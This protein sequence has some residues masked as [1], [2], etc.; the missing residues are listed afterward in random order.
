MEKNR[1]IT[2]ISA[3]IM[4]ATLCAQQRGNGKLSAWVQEALTQQSTDRRAAEEHP[5]LI[6]VFIR[7]TEGK[8]LEMLQEY[9]CTIYAQLGDICIATVPMDRLAELSQQP[10]VVRIEASPSAHTTMDEVAKA[11]NVLPAYQKTAEHEAFTGKGVVMGVMD[12]GFDLSHPTFYDDTSM[13]T[14]RIKAFWDQLADCPDASR[15]PVGREYTTSE[16]I[17]TV[18]RATDGK[19]QN[20]GTHTTGI[21]AGSGYDTTYRGIAY[22][23]DI[24]LVA[25]A[26]TEDTIYINKQDLNKYTS[27]T[28]ALGFKYLFDYAEQQGRPCVVSFSEGYTAYLDEDDELYDE[29]LK[30]LTGPGRI[31]VASAGNESLNP[32]YMVKPV[33]TE[34]AGAFL[35]IYKKTGI[36]RLLTDGKPT[37]RLTHYPAVEQEGQTL[38]LCMDGE[39]WEEGELRDTLFVNKD[40]LALHITAYTSGLI[41]GKT[42]YLIRMTGN[43]EVSAIG[44]IAIVTEGSDCQ[45]ELFGSSSNLLMTREDDPR[46]NA[47]QRGHN[48]LAPGCLAAPICVGATIHRF[49]YVNS[50]GETTNCPYEV[51]QGQWGPFSSMG[52]TMGGRAK[53]DV[54]APGMYVISSMSSY[55]MEEHPDETAT[56]TAYSNANGRRY[57]WAIK[58][59]TSM[60]TPIVAGAIALWL[61]AKPTLTREDIMGILQRTCRYPEEGLTYPNE[62]YGYGEIDIYRGLLDVLGV[63]GIQ[64]ISLHQPQGVRIFACDGL[65][66]LV[67]DST[68]EQSVNLNIYSTGGSLLYKERLKAGQREIK[69]PLPIKGKGIYVVQLQGDNRVT[70]SQLIRL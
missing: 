28:D 45:A 27:A 5:M 7:T 68:P 67:F 23:S 16:E 26:V 35:G 32:T 39:R 1:I 57:S 43:I 56:H 41:E 48:V 44:H 59:G 14:Y 36:Y 31:L 34:A 69:T 22:E 62:R 47:S 70:G 40:T 10:D 63:T 51:G 9:G 49:S 60:S 13:G 21:A 64:N 54:S 66:H 58:S 38:V 11:V 30:R 65:L 18:G 50:V 6:T 29:F 61:Q 33:G 3:L 17:L 20:H 46:W 19:S 55:Y 4:A 15:F 25:N 37:L 42:M 2:I 8:S 53:P 12:V 52:P 24:A